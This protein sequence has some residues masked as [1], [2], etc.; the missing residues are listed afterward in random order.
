MSSRASRRIA[1]QVVLVAVLIGAAALGVTA[2]LPTGERPALVASSSTS[3]TVL[4]TTVVRDPTTTTAP[5][6][7]TSSSTTTTAAA[8]EVYGTY[9]ARAAGDAVKI[10]LEVADG[11]VVA[12]RN[13]TAGNDR[14]AFRFPSVDAG[15]YRVVIT[16]T[17]PASGGASSISVVRSVVFEV[18][19]TRSAKVSCTPESCTTALI[20]S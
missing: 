2:L 9:E 7:S 4:G 10:E 20:E 15:L 3:V 6:I 8:A 16:D 1:L 17:T 11:P 12:T 14:V 5:P 18:S 19:P 13:E